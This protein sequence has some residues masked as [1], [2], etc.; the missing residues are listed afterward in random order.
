MVRTY[1]PTYTTTYHT[2]YM[3]T[4]M[5][6]YTL[7]LTPPGLRRGITSTSKPPYP[8]CQCTCVLMTGL[9]FCYRLV[10]AIACLLASVP[11]V[12]PDPTTVLRIY[13]TSANDQ[14]LPS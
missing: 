2:Q 5:T 11:I 12:S 8:T 6:T 10:D 9:G 1:T 13:V 14:R 4:Y 3:P 7:H